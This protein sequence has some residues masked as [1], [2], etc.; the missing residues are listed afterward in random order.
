MS[1]QLEGLKNININVMISK[2]M[3]P[4]LYYLFWVAVKSAIGIEDIFL[5]L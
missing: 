3:N 4:K 2:L 1:V 5:S